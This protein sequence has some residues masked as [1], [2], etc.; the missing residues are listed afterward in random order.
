MVPK[1]FTNVNSHYSLT[2]LQ[3]GNRNGKQN[4]SR[5]RCSVEILKNMVKGRKQKNEKLKY[6]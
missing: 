1:D 4:N 5:N 6:G 2:E 3:S